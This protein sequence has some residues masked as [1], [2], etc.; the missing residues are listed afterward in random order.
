MGMKV[1]NLYLIMSL[2]YRADNRTIDIT[3]FITSRTHYGP[4]PSRDHYAQSVPTLSSQ[5]ITLGKYDLAPH[6]GHLL[7]SP[8][9]IYPLSICV[10]NRQH[11]PLQ[12]RTLS[13]PIH[14]FS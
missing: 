1:A 8:N 12:S 3:T 13:K 2:P 4:H 5:A 14:S 9:M 11:H 7:P 6:Q 10:Q